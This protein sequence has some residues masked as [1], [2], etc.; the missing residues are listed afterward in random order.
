[1][2]FLDAWRREL[3]RRA[4]DAVVVECQQR[5]RETDFRLFSEYYMCT[6]LEK[7]TWKQLA[8]RYGINEWK[9]ASHKSEWVKSRLHHAL[10]QL[11]GEYTD[12]EEEIDDELRLLLQ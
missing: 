1:M 9:K 12:S 7:P 5:Q 11:I 10:R 2:A 3:L 8:A 4:L 6:E